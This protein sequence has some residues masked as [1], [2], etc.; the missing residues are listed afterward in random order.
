MSAN[1]FIAELAQRAGLPADD[2]TVPTFERLASAVPGHP[3]GIVG[4]HF[5]SDGCEAPSHG[6]PQSATG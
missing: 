4:G 5:V 6:R 1:E 2:L 3:H